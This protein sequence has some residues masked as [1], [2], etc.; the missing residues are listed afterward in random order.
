[1]SRIAA[2]QGV[3]NREL[4]LPPLSKLVA[5]MPEAARTQMKQSLLEAVERAVAEGGEVSFNL[6]DIAEDLWSINN[7]LYAGKLLIVEIDNTKRFSVIKHGLPPGVDNLL[8]RGVDVVWAAP[9]SELTGSS[10]INS[11]MDIQ[12]VRMWRLISVIKASVEYATS[13]GTISGYRA[14]IEQ[15]N[16][17][18]LDLSAD[19]A[20]D[21]RRMQSQWWEASQAIRDL[22]SEYMNGYVTINDDGVI[23]EALVKEGSYIKGGD[24]IA[25]I[26]PTSRYGVI[27]G[28]GASSVILPGSK[29][30]VTVNC[31]DALVLLP[32]Q[33]K[34]MSM[35]ER[36]K[37][38]WLAKKLGKAQEKLRESI[39][40]SGSVD[41]PALTPSG[42]T[43][44]TL[45]AES[46]F[47]PP[48]IAL[49]DPEVA[50]AAKGVGVTV[51][52][53]GGKSK[54]VFEGGVLDP[55]TSCKMAFR[56]ESR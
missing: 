31:G 53:E 10:S 44:V 6:R 16:S 17:A 15:L 42:Y 41:V 32:Q 45:E 48:K 7:V 23:D 8:F 27:L 25:L 22:T 36:S 18:E 33:W 43:I 13:S 51:K 1:M 56:S 47:S 55:G 39:S 26:R 2:I 28:A 29:Y 11:L 20:T 52:Q 50:E 46:Q 12:I 4:G 49:E 19:E 34:K 24:T 9:F 3:I 35:L 30:K 21:G 40:F 37:S 5:A 14:A 54:I 38:D